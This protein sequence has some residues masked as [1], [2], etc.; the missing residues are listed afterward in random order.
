MN[1]IVQHSSE[2]NE[3]YTPRLIVDPSRETL[4]VIHVDPASSAL[5]QSVVGARVWYGQGSPFGEDGMRDGP[6]GAVLTR[7]REWPGTVFLNPPGGIEDNPAFRGSRAAYWWEQLFRQYTNG[8][9]TEAIF[10]CFTMAV[11]RTAQ[12]QG[13]KSRGTPPPFAFPFCVPR[14]RVN[15]D[16]IVDGARVPT[17]GAPSDTAIVYLPNKKDPEAGFARFQ[18][19]FS[20]LGYVRE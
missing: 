16:K 12:H 14:S 17:T 4:R 1:D 11:F 8:L 5:A 9:T 2:T 3:H 19:A 15:Y 18:K 7:R 13:L 20:P 10:V 6:I